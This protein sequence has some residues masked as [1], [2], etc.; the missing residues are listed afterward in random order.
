MNT[1]ED[2]LTVTLPKSVATVIHGAVMVYM[3]EYY[4]PTTKPY[5]SLVVNNLPEW[6]EQAQS[7]RSKKS[8]ATFGKL[9]GQITDFIGRSEVSS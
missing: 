4:P 5:I 8:K 3:A 7:L 6:H 2:L 1:Q 9:M